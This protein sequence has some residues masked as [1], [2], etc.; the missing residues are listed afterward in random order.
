MLDELAG[1]LGAEHHGAKPVYD[2]LRYLNGLCQ[3][4]RGGDFFPNLGVAIRQARD[5]R[6]SES[7]PKSF[8]PPQPSA[9]VDREAG[10]RAIAEI[11]ASLGTSFRMNSVSDPED[12]SG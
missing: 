3:R 8:P 12:C 2:V 9:P 1:R 10:L 5:Q 11:R 7:K 4:A 6:Q